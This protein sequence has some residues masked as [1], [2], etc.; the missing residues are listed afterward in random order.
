LPAPPPHRP[1]SPT[2]PGALPP[3][4][5]SRAGDLARHLDMAVIGEV[6][7]GVGLAG[8]RSVLSHFIGDAAGSHAALLGALAQA[9]RA[10][11]RE[12]AHALK[13]ASASL[14]L[15]ALQAAAARLE[16]RGDTLSA[17]GRA[18]AAREL[19]ALLETTRDLLQRMGLL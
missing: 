12:R 19:R 8:Y 10:A 2:G 5:R 3:A 16:A 7:L 17:S 11:L 6:C 1:A 9:D 14:G 13:G 4:R 15:C 18:E